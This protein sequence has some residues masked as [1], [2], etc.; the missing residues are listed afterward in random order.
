MFFMKWGILSLILQSTLA[1]FTY[2]SRINGGR[3]SEIEKAPFM[4]SF[5][6]I[7]GSKFKHICGAVIISQKYLL[8]AA[9]C[10]HSNNVDWFSVAVGTNKKDDESVIDHE[11]KRIIVHEKYDEFGA[12][13]KYDI[14]LIELEQP[15]K[16]NERTKVIS[17]NGSFFEGEVE[18]IAYGFG[19]VYVSFTRIEF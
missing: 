6:E 19:G 16:L 17:L 12:P 2:T 13:F 14:A 10:C 9:Q 11:I 1:E 7:R 3:E 5:R 8:T 4:A 18:S 15:L